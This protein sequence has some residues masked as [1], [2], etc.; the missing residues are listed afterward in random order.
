MDLIARKIVYSLIWWKFWKKHQRNQI[1]T[2]SRL[3]GGEPSKRATQKVSEMYINTNG[4]SSKFASILIKRR[5]TIGK[6]DAVSMFNGVAPKCGGV[7]DWLAVCEDIQTGKYAKRIESGRLLVD[8]PVAYRKFKTGLPAV[9]FGGTFNMARSITKLHSTTGFLIPDLDHLDN[10]QEV[11]DAL[12]QDENIWFMFRSPS[13]NGIKC[14][15]RSNNIKTD[16]DHKRF[17]A[18][19]ERY[20]S[21]QYQV[22]IDPACKDICRLTF[23]SSDSNAFLSKRPGYFDISRWST[24]RKVKPPPTTSST[25]TNDA[26]KVKYG[27]KVLESCC[28]KISKSSFGEQHNVRLK[29]SR[30]VGGYIA[31]GFIDEVAAMVVLREAVIASGAKHIPMAMS[32]IEDGIL[33]GKKQPVNIQQRQSVRNDKD[34]QYNLDDID[35]IDGF[36]DIDDIE[37]KWRHMTTHDDSLTTDDDILTTLD[38]TKTGDKTALNLHAVIREW[39]KN[40]VGCFTSEQL[41]R[42]LVLTTR[43]EK[44]QRSKILS[45]C[46]EKKLIKRNM[47]GAGK[48]TI[49]NSTLDEINIDDIDEKCFDILL[50]FNLDRFTSIPKKSIIVL[51][52]SSNAGKTALILNI[53]KLN[54]HH[55]YR[56]LYLMSEMGRGEYVDRLRKFKDVPFLDWKKITA[57]ERTHDFDGAIESHNPEGLT[58]IDFLEDADGEF[59]KIPSDIRAIYD[60]LGDGVAVIAI[61]KKTDSDYARGGQGTAEKARLY[62]TVDLITALDHSIICALKIIKNKRYINRNIQGHEIHFRITGGAHIEAVSPWLRSTDTDRQK[63]KAKYEQENNTSSSHTTIK[64]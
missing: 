24:D 31:S 47:R 35:D 16:E 48:F 10:V 25:T 53:L 2:K 58:C 30:L 4:L 23:L 26:W 33:N 27:D 59:Y 64:I 52:G 1:K 37:E 50:P 32:T 6:D 62:L 28:Q 61:Q 60:S 17:F 46:V 54:L 7:T 20:F 44:K 19:A 63:Y 56:K 39:I 22:K 49:I 29:A 14:A 5:E 57:A 36:D 38:D 15:M 42:D 40:S 12:S 9:T 45:R 11:F 51:A 55:S 13:G 34:I 21:E 18:S 41:D 43:D 8:D 3:L